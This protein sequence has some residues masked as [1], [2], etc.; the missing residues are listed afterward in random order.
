MLY[1]LLAPVFLLLIIGRSMLGSHA[2]FQYA[3]PIGVAYGFLPLTKQVCN[4]LGG[5]GEGI[6][7]YFLSPTPIRTV[8]LGKNILHI[9]LFL[10]ELILACSIVVFRFGVPGREIV[11]ATFCWL[12]FAVP[13]QLAAGDL[14][15]I[16]MAYRMTLTRISRQEGATG[17]AL[18][19]LLI[20]VVLLGVGAVIFLSA[21][22][23]GHAG[24][25][26]P[27]FLVLGGVAFW[28][29]MLML[30]NVDRM[31]EERREELIATIAKRE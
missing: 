12:L 22:W 30:R 26:A 23:V 8:M 6:Q 7:L 28:A 24:L 13:A 9:G 17:N 15:S 27:I 5:E 20:Q 11:L 19:G 4:S 10:L 1:G 21:K 14:L 3:L 29:W 16:L 2:V 25:A 18:L 31:A